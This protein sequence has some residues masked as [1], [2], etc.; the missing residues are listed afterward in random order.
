MAEKKENLFSFH[1]EHLVLL[2][3][4]RGTSGTASRKHIKGLIV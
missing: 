1:R 4:G 3:A 2:N